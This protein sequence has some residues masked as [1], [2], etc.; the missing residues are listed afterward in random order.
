MT[1][2]VMTKLNLLVMPIKLGEEHNVYRKNGCVM[3]TPTVLMGL[4]KTLLYTIAPHLSHV[5]TI[6]LLAAT[7]DASIK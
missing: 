2:N 3:V 5:V 7:A 6:N 4:M 1:V